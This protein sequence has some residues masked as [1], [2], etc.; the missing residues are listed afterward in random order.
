MIAGMFS[1]PVSVKRFN[2]RRETVL[3]DEL[4]YRDKAREAKS[5]L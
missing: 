5:N 4:V 2:G 3:S 1:V